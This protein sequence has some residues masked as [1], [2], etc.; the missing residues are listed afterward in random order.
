[1]RKRRYTITEIEAETITT[2]LRWLI[3]KTEINEKTPLETLSL[4]EKAQKIY[5][6]IINYQW[7]VES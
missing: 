4:V 1:M 2:A 3:I 5:S 6:K 7:E